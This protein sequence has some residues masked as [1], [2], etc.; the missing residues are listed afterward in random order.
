MF[1]SYYMVVIALPLY[2]AQATVPNDES[3]LIQ[4]GIRN[5]RETTIVPN[6]NKANEKRFKCEL[7]DRQFRHAGNLKYHMRIH[8]G[9][10]NDIC[11]VCDKQFGRAG[12]LRYHMR[13]HT[14]EINYTC[15]V[16]DKR[17]NRAYNLKRH[18]TA[19]HTG[20]KITHVS[21]DG[22]LP[23]QAGIRNDKEITTVA[24]DT[25]TKEKSFKCE[26]CDKR[27]RRASSL[28]R[29]IRIHTGEKNY[30]CKICDKQFIQAYNLKRHMAT[31]T[32]E[33]NYACKVCQK[34]FKQSDHLK[35]HE[36][37]H[38]NVQSS[39]F[40]RTDNLKEY[41]NTHKSSSEKLYST[42]SP[43]ISIPEVIDTEI[44]IRE[45]IAFVGI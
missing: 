2:I 4:A 15:K 6:D 27:F 3:P 21:N 33:R 5:D 22:N 30:I 23:I 1:A 16:C 37:T 35:K 10:K 44:L 13:I 40:T 36:L 38:R 42:V 9:E 14:G 28:K 18:M 39:N 20:E 12:I 25:K 8:I 11:E 45:I 24:N 19:I 29:H 32:G 17:F 31:H 34:T 26:I 43:F 41:M 7:C